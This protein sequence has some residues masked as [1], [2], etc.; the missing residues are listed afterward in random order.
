M[1]TNLVDMYSGCNLQ[2][3]PVVTRTIGGVGYYILTSREGRSFRHKV[4]TEAIW[5]LCRLVQIMAEYKAHMRVVIQLDEGVAVRRVSGSKQTPEL[6]RTVL[7]R[8]AHGNRALQRLK[9]AVHCLTPHPSVAQIKHGQP[10]SVIVTSGT[11]QPLQH[12]SEEFQL[13]FD[14]KRSYA[15]V[16]PRD[17]YQVVFLETYKGRPVMG[18]YERRGDPEYKEALLYVICG[19]HGKLGCGGALVFFTSYQ[20]LQEYR[21]ELDGRVGLFFEPQDSATSGEELQRF[22]ARARTGPAVLC[23]VYGGKYAEGIDFAD[24]ECRMAVLLGV[25]YAPIVAPGTAERLQ[26][27]GPAGW[28]WYET[29]AYRLASQAAGRCLR[30]R[31]DVGQVVLADSRF[32]RG[33]ALLSPWLGAGRHAE[34]FEHFVEENDWL[35]RRLGHRAPPRPAGPA[36]ARPQYRNA[37]AAVWGD[38]VRAHK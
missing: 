10:H 23:C 36:P 13:R 31:G 25:P 34:T 18:T 9:L 11:L 26:I 29:R 20:M 37:Y 35:R 38:I 15:H 6:L 12:L 19:L 7:R 3:M 8:C 24:D 33:A 5:S 32:A 2:N 17:D 30:R 27:G 1:A 22:R 14:L 4:N 28:R 21:A 16:C